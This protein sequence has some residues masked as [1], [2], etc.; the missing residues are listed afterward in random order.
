MLRAVKMLAG[1]AII[2][3]FIIALVYAYNFSDTKN[4][5][6]TKGHV[7]E[8]KITYIPRDGYYGL[9]KYIYLVENV[10]Y[11]NEERYRAK[12]SNP[13]GGVTYEDTLS[14]LNAHYRKGQAVDVHYSPWSPNNSVLR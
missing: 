14:F 1:L 13:R 10:S 12:A 8:S 7:V 3:G 6:G 4:W 5:P 11:I 2:S 9:V